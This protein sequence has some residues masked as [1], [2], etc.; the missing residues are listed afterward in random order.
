MI[1][2]VMIE[3]SSNNLL[4]AKLNTSTG[5]FYVKN[6][7]WSGQICESNIITINYDSRIVKYDK[8]YDLGDINITMGYE[9]AIN[10]FGVDSDNIL[11]D[12]STINKGKYRRVLDIHYS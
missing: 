7:H 8:I 6:G 11:V 4:Y 10:S 1:K 5:H 3:L 2:L 12:E 9:D